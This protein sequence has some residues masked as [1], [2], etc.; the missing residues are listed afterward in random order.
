MNDI[1]VLKTKRGSMKC[2]YGMIDHLMASNKTMKDIFSIHDE[3]KLTNGNKPICIYEENG[4][5]K[6]LKYKDY[7]KKVEKYAASFSAVLKNIEKDSFV[8]MKLTNSF[9]WPLTFWAL[10][11]AGYK[12]LLIN[13]I[14]GQIESEKLLKEA[15]AK[16]IIVDNKNVYEVP[17]ININS[18]D[19]EEQYHFT[20][21]W[22][23][24]VAFCTSG[25][26]GD[27]KI[28][29]YNGEALS[30]QLNAAFE[31]PQTTE[32]IMYDGDIRLLAIIP[33]SHI[34]GFVA[35]FLWY[36]FFG[37]T[38]VFPRSNAPKDLV[39]ACKNHQCTHVY[40]VPMFWDNVAKLFKQTISL[41]KPKKQGLV[42]KVCDY[43]N[44]VITKSE[45]GLASSKFVQ[46]K[47]QKQVLGDKIV[48]CISGGSALSKDTLETINGLGYHLYNGYGMTEIGITSV[49]LSKDVKQRNK[50]SIG[51]ALHGV[52]YSLEDE[53]LLVKSPYLHI[54]RF[55]NGKRV[56]SD[57]DKN[58]FFHTG[59]L[60]CI[61]N[62]GHAFIKGKKKDV[63][64]S[65]NGENIYPDEIEA[66]FKGLPFVKLL[67]LIGVENDKEE[68]LTMIMN[69]EKDL[70][71]DELE[72][73]K[74]SIKETNELL[75]VAMQ[76][77]D[78]YIDKESLPI[79]ASM[80]IKRFVLIDEFKN[81]PENFLK[82]GNGVIVSF[83]GFDEKEV[84]KIKE[85]LISIFADALYVDKK[86]I[87]P[88]SHVI[89]DLG[90]DSLA[91]MSILATI[92]DEFTIHI[93]TEMIGKLNSVNEFALYILRNKQ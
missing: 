35:V 45:A 14:L 87:A 67:S 36:T 81:K 40:A 70:S 10:L 76:V 74:N 54:A 12:P 61:E 86:I 41:Q 84:S 6:S 34:F 2:F 29:I 21:Y 43:N 57:L 16:A 5:T 3:T 88:S 4:T 32:D 83:D 7:I 44:G 19:F 39:D 38:I 91:Y 1:R 58:G 52:V 47:I 51:K 69:L 8:G 85:Q 93:P 37:M 27:S 90:G 48:Y 56:E 71:K 73:L 55:V 60:A 82:L 42:K 62:D 59:D 46:S 72:T 63:I 89:A 25:T 92:E 75:P 15:G 26:T 17:T 66:R 64:I 53:E 80:K 68:V 30:Y 22:S 20:P 50:G 11:M 24:E 13:P 77:R 28:Y 31:M 23:N 79:N 49:E 9:K 65:S 78:F 18:L 33:F